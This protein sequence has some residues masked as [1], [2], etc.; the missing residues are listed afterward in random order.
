MSQQRADKEYV[1]VFRLQENLSSE[2]SFKLAFDRLKG[3]QFQRPPLR[4]YRS[5]SPALARLKGPQFKRPPWKSAPRS[6]QVRSVCNLELLEFDA[7]KNLGVF[8][9]RCEAGTYISALCVHLGI[10]LGVGA[11]MQELRKV[12]SGL[13][14]ECNL[15]RGQGH[16]A[17]RPPLRRQHRNRRGN[18][19]DH[20]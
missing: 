1:C 15:L 14:S 18:C 13:G 6:L 12:G 4:P 20:N 16:A 19:P 9:V 10:L 8:R 17:R 3:P 2:E 7:E 5:F 11:Q